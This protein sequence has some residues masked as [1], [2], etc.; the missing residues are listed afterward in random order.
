MNSI[1]YKKKKNSSQIAFDVVY[2]YTQGVGFV[3]CTQG[4]CFRYPGCLIP[5]PR[6]FDSG[7]QG[8]LPP[9]SMLQVRYNDE[10][11]TA[12]HRQQQE[13]RRDVYRASRL[14]YPPKVP[15]SKDGEEGYRSQHRASP[16][17]QAFTAPPNRTVSAD[18]PPLAFPTSQQQPLPSRQCSQPR[19]GPTR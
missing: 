12:Q 2:V 16:V 15:R 1:F 19:P 17:S 11:Q 5:V 10:L 3:S 8:T 14:G 9:V 13:V 4:V 6:V 7:T 18:Y